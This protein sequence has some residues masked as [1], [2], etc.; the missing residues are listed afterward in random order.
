MFELA[1]IPDTLPPEC[2]EVV[3]QLW[4]YL[5][6]RLAPE[7]SEKLRAHIVAC[8]NCFR[9][10]EFQLRFFALLAEMRDRSVAAAGLREQVL[11]ALTLE[12][13]SPG[14]EN[15]S[16]TTREDGLLRS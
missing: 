14:P 13:W 15:S 5:D 8:A 2:Q 1:D 16:P 7:L 9:Y 10:Q 11:H 3:K 4:D 6:G 12:G